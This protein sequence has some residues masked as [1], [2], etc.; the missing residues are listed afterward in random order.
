MRQICLSNEGDMCFRNSLSE[1]EEGE[2]LEEKFFVGAD[3]RSQLRVRNTREKKKSRTK[4]AAEEARELFLTW[5][6]QMCCYRQ[7]N[8]PLGEMRTSWMTSIYQVNEK[9]PTLKWVGKAETHLNHKPHHSTPTYSCERNPS[10]QLPHKEFYSC[11]SS[12][13]TLKASTQGTDFQN[14]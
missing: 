10:L 1:N 13:Q 7:K 14:T 11:T 12:A 3:C 9:T 8:I 2:S 6:H 4:K 5:V